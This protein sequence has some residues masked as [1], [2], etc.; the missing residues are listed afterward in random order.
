[1]PV[2]PGPGAAAARHLDIGR[3]GRRASVMHT[4][5]PLPQTSFYLWSDAVTVRNLFPGSKPTA[6]RSRQNPNE[7]L[8]A[9]LSQGMERGGPLSPD[10]QQQVL[11]QQPQPR[12][13]VKEMRDSAVTENYLRQLPRRWRIGDVYAP[14]DLGAV[15][16]AKWKSR[17]PPVTDVVD[18]FGFNPIDNYKVRILSPPRPPYPR[19]E[20]GPKIPNKTT[21]SGT[22]T[23]R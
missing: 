20:Q 18:T 13:V 7:E 6:R 10:E 5:P 2:W 17:R 9:M 8:Q 1:M 23:S 15:E 14:R 11:Q 22:R 4:H 12:D 21:D 16:Q 3:L 19:D